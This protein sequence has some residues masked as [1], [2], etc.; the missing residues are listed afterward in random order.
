[1]DTI[2][3]NANKPK[4]IAH[5]GLSGL[6]QENTCAAFVAAGN[7]SYFGIE[8]DVHVTKDGQYAVI[9]DDSTLRVAGVEL[10]VEETELQ[11]LRQLTLKPKPFECPRAD[12]CIPTLEEYITVCKKY[13]K[14]A[15]LELKD[16]MPPEHVWQIASV[17]CGMDYLEHTIFISFALENLVALREKYPAQPAQ[18]L[19]SEQPPVD[20]LLAVLQQHDLD[21]DIYHKSLT[22]EAVDALH[23][24]GRVVNVWTVDT[25]EDAQRVMDLGVDY[26]TSNILE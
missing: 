18:Y 21:L 12:L 23:K 9:H 26:I 5:R 11:T 4:M 2:K 7:R 22:K 25:V 1:M 15:V 17:I 20:E 8:T 6:E 13:G 16:P 3:L 14:T 19:L 10:C 24:A